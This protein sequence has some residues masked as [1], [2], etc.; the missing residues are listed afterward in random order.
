MSIWGEYKKRGGGG[1][2]KKTGRVGE[3]PREGIKKNMRQTERARD[4]DRQREREGGGGGGETD[5]ETETDRQSE[6]CRLHYVSEA[7]CFNSND[8]FFKSSIY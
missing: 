5:R 6:E 7:S 2:G 3:R 8:I 1:E 4:R